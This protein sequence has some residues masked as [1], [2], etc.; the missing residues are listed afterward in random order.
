MGIDN[1]Y[2]FYAKNNTCPFD[3]FGQLH[4]YLVIRHS[5]SKLE[6]AFRFIKYTDPIHS[7]LVKAILLHLNIPFI[8]T[9][10]K[11]EIQS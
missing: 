8:I 1:N 7:H 4:E 11:I 9:G 10:L 6:Y 5:G 2:K 3:N